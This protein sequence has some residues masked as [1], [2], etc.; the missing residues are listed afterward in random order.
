MYDTMKDKRIGRAEVIEKFGVP[1][2]K[3]IEVQ[4]LIG[5]STDNVPGVPG[6]G[7]KTAA[8]LIGEYGDLETVLKRAGEIKQDKRRQSLIDN[9]ELARISKRLVTLDQHVALDMPIED[10]LVHEPDYRNLIAFLK[11][12]EFS[13]LTKRVAEAAEHR[14]R[15]RSKP[16]A[17]L[18]RGK[19]RRRRG[20]VTR[21]PAAAKARP[22][23]PLSGGAQRAVP[24]PATA[25]RFRSPPCAPRKSARIPIDRT[26]YEIVRDLARLKAWIARAIDLGLLAVDTE[27]T[28][29]DPMQA[30]LCG[31]SLAVGAERGL[32]RAARAP[33]ERRRPR[34]VRCR[35]R[36]DQIPRDRCARGDQ[37]AAGRPR[38]A[39]DRP[40]PEIRHADF[41]AARH[42]D[43]PHDDTMLMSYVLDAGRSDHGI[44]PL[45]MRYF[46]HQTIDFNEVTG[47]GKSR[48]T[49][50]CIEIDKA[51]EYAAEDADVT[52]RLWNI[53]KP[54]LTAEHM[55]NVY[56]TLER[57][58]VPVLARMER[59]G[60]SIDRQV[61]TQLSGEFAQGD[62]A[63]GG[64]DPE[65][66][67]R[68][69]QS[70]QPQADR[71]PAVRRRS[72]CPA[73][74]RPRPAQWSTGARALED[75]AEQ[76]H[77]LPQKILDWRQV[78]KL[79]STYTDALPTYVNPTTQRVHT[80]YSLASTTTGRLSSSEPNLQ[81]IPIRT[82]AGRKI[83][84]AFIAQPATS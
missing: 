32:L 47:T 22:T 65:A 36:A 51:A 79:R 34:T 16:D 11:A 67:R 40:E 42:R 54:R 74:P 69:G 26:K 28:S 72:A 21:A 18:I 58:M 61:F 49:F 46:A 44:E 38:H 45:S 48:L 59:R 29:L 60:I 76:G 68:A 3:V 4:A 17:R 23:L 5:D 64:R 19:A 43:R 77:E 83:R 8:Q 57:P 55:N 52:L 81:N 70:R 80:S 7:S 66:G 6:I 27:T 41:R 53:L 82:E 56:E 1:P 9:A 84:R 2:E 10:L 33:Q 75:L 30:T 39:Q 37:A 63:A 73:A 14:R 12:M 25:R 35:H 20:R 62:D 50:D 13:T 24:Q 31:F 78:S 15:R 71:R